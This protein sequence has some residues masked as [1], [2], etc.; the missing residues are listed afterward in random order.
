MSGSSGSKVVWEVEDN[1]VVEDPNDND[2]IGLRGF[3]FN[4]FGKYERGGGGGKISIE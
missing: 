2:E 3:D 4:L 1:H